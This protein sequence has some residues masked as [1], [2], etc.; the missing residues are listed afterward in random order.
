MISQTEKPWG[1][2]ELLVSG[3]HFELHKLTVKAGGF[4]SIHFHRD[5]I[6]YIHVASGVLKMRTYDQAGRMICEQDCLPG[7][8]SIAGPEIRHQFYGLT[9]AVAYEVYMSD[10][11]LDP[12]DIVRLSEGGAA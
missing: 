1:L 12:N 3:P 6:Q 9:D 5:K 4:C 11:P 8:T 2:D 7:E 10:A